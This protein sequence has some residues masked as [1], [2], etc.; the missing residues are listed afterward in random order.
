[1]SPAGAL[2]VGAGVLLFATGCGGRG[3]TTEQVPG[4]SI[5]TRPIG[6]GPP[7]RL[8]PLG[9]A[10]ATGAPIGGL[11]C[12]PGR[13]A[14]PI[15]AH[16]EIFARRDTLVIPAGI[17]ML[18]GRCGYP[19]R[20]LTQTGLIV[21][22]RR[23]LTLGDLFAVWGQPLRK[24]RLAGFSGPILAFIDGRRVRG[25]VRRIPIRHHAEIVVEVSGYVPPHAHYVFPRSP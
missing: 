17:G 14:G 11:R 13:S 22:D 6:A 2:A 8:P 24:R 5:I 18:P 19:L 20:T 9:T 1:M 21:A 7:F 15:V 4:P 3:G 12:R 16:L 10:A 23:G 25:D